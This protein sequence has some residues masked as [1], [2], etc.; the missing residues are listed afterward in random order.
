MLNAFRR[1][2]QRLQ[3][4]HEQR[5]PRLERRVAHLEELLEGL[6]DSVHRESVRRDGEATR[7]SERTAPGAMARALGD[8]AR[9]RGLR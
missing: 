8:D 6:Q 1:R 3:A 7:L 5:L 4:S 2:R 9:K